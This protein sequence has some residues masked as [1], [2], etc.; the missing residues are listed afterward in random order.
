MYSSLRDQLIK[1]VSRNDPI[2]HILI[3]PER[4]FSVILVLD[5]LA[6]ISVTAVI[7]Y[8]TMELFG[9]WAVPISTVLISVVVILFGELLPKVFAVR[10][11]GELARFILIIS[12]YI[13]KI[14]GFIAVP[15]SK[16]FQKVS[17]EEIKKHM[18][19]DFVPEQ[20]KMV[21]G[22]MKLKDLELR[23]LLVRREFVATVDIEMEL[24][25]VI[26]IIEKTK[27][28]RYPV[29]SDGRV[30]GILLSKNLLCSIPELSEN[31]K[32]RDVIEKNP[33]IMKP[34]RFAP[35]N[36][37][38]LEQL[39]DFREW[40]THMVCVIDETGEFLGIVTLEDIVEEITG[41][42][43]DEFSVPT[44][45]FWKDGDYIYARGITPI[46]DINR[47][48]ETDINEEFETIASMIISI[49]GRI[50]SKDEKI[51]F[52]S[53]EV[54]ILDSSKGKINLVRMKKI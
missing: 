39:I 16:I 33:D 47:E 49:L 29:L 4:F 43:Y 9:A 36:K 31:T 51:K 20:L 37:S 41:D 2:Y 28:T 48:F 7:T 8:K 19:S 35:P 42:I 10:Y 24:K 14:L 26:S 45:N 21:R 44:K 30:F 6:N 25:E 3:H 38:V 11:R 50:P 46:R 17:E 53:W 12:A 54:E 15:L 32:L 18:Y 13:S 27:H 22:I 40:R 34:A 52:D 23:D 1:S 5:N